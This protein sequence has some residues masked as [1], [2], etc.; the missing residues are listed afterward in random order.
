MPDK[1]AFAKG[2]ADERPKPI[3]VEPAD[4]VGGLAAVPVLVQGTNE[5]SLMFR[6][7][8][9]VRWRSSLME[10]VPGFGVAVVA[11]ACLVLKATDATR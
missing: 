11:V 3:R 1:G 4:D 5:R 2:L 9:H 6:S 7:S 8:L 10:Y